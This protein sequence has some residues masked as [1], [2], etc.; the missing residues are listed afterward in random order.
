[1]KIKEILDASRLPPEQE[2]TL[3]ELQESY[4]GDIESKTND[5]LVGLTLLLKKQEKD[6]DR[7]SDILRSTTGD[8]RRGYKIIQGDSGDTYNGIAPSRGLMDDFRDAKLAIVSATE[9]TNLGRTKALEEPRLQ[10][11]EEVKDYKSTRTRLKK[12]VKGLT[13]EKRYLKKAVE[14]FGPVSLRGVKRKEALEP[15]V[16][17]LD[18]TVKKIRG[19]VEALKLERE[20]VIDV[21]AERAQREF[22][23]D[24]SDVDYNDLI[25]GASLYGIEATAKAAAFRAAEI[26]NAE[27]KELGNNE[28]IA[29][30]VVQTQAEKY[31]KCIKDAVQTG[32]GR[33]VLI[34]MSELNERESEVSKNLAELKSQRV[35]VYTKLFQKFKKP[36]NELPLNIEVHGPKG[37]VGS[38]ASEGDVVAT[39]WNYDGLNEFNE[40]KKKMDDLSKQYQELSNEIREGDWQFR[41]DKARKPLKWYHLRGELK[42]NYEK[43]EDDLKIKKSKLDALE[44]ELN[45][46]VKEVADLRE[47]VKVTKEPVDVL[48]YVNPQELNNH[49]YIHDNYGRGYAGARAKDPIQTVEDF[50]KFFYE[51]RQK[52]LEQIRAERAKIENDPFSQAILKL[53]K[54]L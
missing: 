39:A 17:V 13:D 38:Y 20:H 3:P 31:I 30:N 47:K 40:S 43:R 8:V 33:D 26:R 29:D 19:S 25:I 36:L 10:H 42:G 34:K 14:R 2:I 21:L 4:G 52:I 11:S 23:K 54:Q 46:L 27:I 53:E 48:A 50:F 24:K 49:L 18:Q 51:E 1:M 35:G 22:W 7:E 44:N 16:G 5:D 41:N 45:R 12:G 6:L 32:E 28:L 37:G 15:K 9:G